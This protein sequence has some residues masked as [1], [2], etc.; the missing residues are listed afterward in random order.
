MFEYLEIYWLTH[1]TFTWYRIYKVSFVGTLERWSSSTIIAFRCWYTTK[2]SPNITLIFFLTLVIRWYLKAW[3]TETTCITWR[4]FFTEF[5]SVPTWFASCLT[6]SSVFIST[7]V[8]ITSCLSRT[9]AGLIFTFIPH[10]KSIIIS[11]ITPKTLYI[12]EYNLAI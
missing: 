3:N 5:N 9:T 7:R 11:P 10:I 4:A 2:I 6:I 1:F 8:T 12:K